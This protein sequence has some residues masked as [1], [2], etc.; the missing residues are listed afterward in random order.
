MLSEAGND[1]AVFDLPKECADDIVAGYGPRAR[2]FPVNVAD[3][4]QVESAVISAIEAL[5]KVHLLV[6]CAGVADAARMLSKDGD[7]FPLDLYRR[8]ID[9]NLVGL[10]DVTRQVVQHMASNEPNEDGERGVVISVASIAGIEGQAGQAAYSASKAGVIGMT[11]PLARDLGSRGIRV[12]TVCPGIFDTGM[13]GSASDQL[14]QRLS[15]IHVFPKRL[16]RPA[17]FAHLVRS[18]AENTMLNGE[19]I[20]LDAATRLAHG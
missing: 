6:N 15:D 19:V 12:L 3:P 4:A 10:F 7:P 2:Y 18:L 9:I 5:G 8:V 17:D 13:L 1:V 14:R 20:R 11:L 16:G